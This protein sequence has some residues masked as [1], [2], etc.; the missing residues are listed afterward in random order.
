MLTEAA[1]PLQNYLD[2]SDPAG[3]ARG[4]WVV[5]D[6]GQP[7]E[8]YSEI[9]LVD[10]NRI[11]LSPPL[12]AAHVFGATV[13]DLAVEEK[14]SPADY[15]VTNA[16]S[17]EITLVSGRF[18]AGNAVLV[19]YLTDFV[20]PEVFAPP[21]ND[22]PDLDESW[23]D[24]TGKDLV[25]GTYSI[26]IW[27]RRLVDL[28][29]F[30]ETNSYRDASPPE[31][32]DILGKEATELEPAEFISSGDNCNKCHVDVLFHGGGRRNFDTCVQCHTSG[33]E[34]R[35]RYVAG[36]AP[37]TPGATVEMMHMIHSIHMGEEL[38]DPES[39]VLVG[40]G[41]AQYPNNFTPHTYEEVIFPTLDGGPMVCRA[42]HGEDNTAWTDPSNRDYPDGDG[43]PVRNWRAAC[44]SCHNSPSTMA[45]INTQTDASGA[46]ACAVCHGP[47]K[48][49]SVETMHKIR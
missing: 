37:E 10:G 11:W 18:G 30:D 28:T 34:D 45:H 32:F 20:V 16:A 42:C 4:E 24:W 40:F 38:Y 46:E 31:T 7:D 41:G 47:G 5:V 44:G 8:E 3:F 25:D 33:S 17:G 22:S 14:E 15:S 35:P 13:M 49:L 19:A 36:N 48:E 23:G 29:L 21:L 27:G 6:D 43:S 2:V 1:S 9:T 26:G 12:S 39:Y